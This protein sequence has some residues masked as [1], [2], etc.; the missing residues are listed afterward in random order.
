MTDD[1]RTLEIERPM[2]A[3]R[4]AIWRAW[5]D[6]KLLELWWCPKP[7]TTEVVA[8]DMRP[9]GA[10]HALMRAPEGETGE[11]DMPGCF[12]D[13]VPAERV[14]FTTALGP[15]WAPQRP[16]LAITAV[17]T[18]TD[19]PDGGTLYRARCL[20]ESVEDTERHAAMGFA[21]GWGVCL[22]QLDAL[23]AGL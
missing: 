2:T 4:A 15:G 1:A 14:V 16:W 11:S 9:G 20:H 7:W 22:A 5:T 23:A 19:A 8:F 12:L 10:F 18:M 3:P 6:P 13:I 17:I 21:E